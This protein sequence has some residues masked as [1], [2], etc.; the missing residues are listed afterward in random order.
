[1]FHFATQRR[2]RSDTRFS[3]AAIRNI[4]KYNPNYILAD[5]AYDTEPIRKCIT[6]K[7]K[8]KIKYH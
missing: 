8:Q 3:K 6:K 2:P 5:R 7:Q 1:M 4:K